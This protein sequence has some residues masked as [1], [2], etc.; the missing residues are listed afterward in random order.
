MRFRAGKRNGSRFRASCAEVCG[1]SSYILDEPSIG[2]HLEDVLRLSG[3]CI[4]W[5]TRVVPCWWLNTTPIF[6]RPVTGCWSWDRMADRA[7]GTASIRYARTGGKWEQPP[8]LTC[9]GC[10]G[11]LP[12]CWLIHGTRWL[13]L[14][15]L[16]GRPAED[17]EMVEDA[18]GL[19]QQDLQVVEL[20]GGQERSAYGAR[21]DDYNR[22]IR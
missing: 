1:G 11:W 9:G 14:R 5:S 22:A 4:G 20:L 8:H 16:F 12:S 15:H 17:P 7:V 2:Q 6:W 3:V 18:R 13:V 10:N 19:R 21:A